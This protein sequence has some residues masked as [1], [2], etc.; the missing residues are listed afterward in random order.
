MSRI[1][2]ARTLWALGPRS[3]VRVGLYR[4]GL[5]LGIHPVQRISAQ[6]A[7]GPF[8]VGAPRSDANLPPADSRWLDRVVRFDWHEEPMPPGTTPDWFANPFGQHGGARADQPWWTISDFGGGDIKGLWEL[9]RFGWVVA[10]AGCAAQ[11]EPGAAARLNAWIA[12]WSA[13]NP[14]YRGPNWK[15]GQEASI[16]VM[17]LAAAAIM[18]DEDAAPQPGLTA[19]I[20]LH[21]A[22]IAPTMGYA[23]GQDNN[24]GTS[25]AAALFIGGSW[26]AAH[27]DMRGAGWAAT[28]RRWLEE[29][30][31]TLIMAD[32]SFS[33]YSVTYH[34]VMLD[35]YTLAEVWRR[36]CG[37]P[38]FS[39]ALM[40]R[41]V[42]ATDWLEAMVDPFTG[43]AP[44]IG[45]SDGARLLPVSATGYRNFMPSL[46]LASILFRGTWVYDKVGYD[47]LPGWLGLSGLADWAV[48]PPS[49]SFDDGGW[50]MLRNGE[51]RAVMRY[52]RFRF[53]PSHA[54][55]LHVD[56]WIHGC[57]VL[58]DAGTY[59]Y[60]DPAVPDGDFAATRFHNTISFDDADQMPRL[61]RFLF[62]DWL[63][64]EAVEP[65]H[66]DDAAQSA[67]AA[68]RDR[69]GNRHHR[70]LTLTDR[71]FTCTD[72]IAGPFQSATLRW[73][74]PP[75]DWQLGLGRVSSPAMA[76]GIMV[77]G[78]PAV[79]T[80]TEGTEAR[81]YLRLSPVVVV[82]VTVDR[83]CT[84]TTTGTF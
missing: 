2:R 1:A 26:L 49:T 61:S 81:E 57:N 60:N 80:L 12:D 58:G 33:Q 21:C 53:R 32:G 23:L 68:Y 6:R 39:S 54:D 65:A 13:R 42:K 75:G 73:R 38:E 50:H 48:P 47:G 14:P 31:Q 17:H 5:K 36:R 72:S 67:A 43:D 35:S 28:G 82:E 24:H 66:G 34:R 76:L 25:E 44:N 41:L 63:E 51:L 27:G 11:G 37:L 3:V 4:L 18:L 19:L 69:R 56:L 52:P 83:P 30:A 62:G 40:Q 10:L 55:A 78:A 9:S 70:R 29:R 7:S 71:A 15:C 59:S 8:F 16:R 45:A 79:I 22:R 74:L 46:H 77:D 20:A 64:A 84:I